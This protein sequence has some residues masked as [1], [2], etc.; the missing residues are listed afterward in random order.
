MSVMDAKPGSPLPLALQEKLLERGRRIHVR[1]N[2]IVVTA[3]ATDTD[4]F[5]VIEGMLQVSLMSARGREL[6]FR[7]I[8]P[9][10]LFGEMAAIEAQP[11]SATVTA[12]RDSTLALIKG[13]AFVDFLENVPGAGLWLACELSQHLRQTTDDLFQLATL[14]V[15][16]RVQCEI[17]R[18]AHVA[19]ITDD[20]AEIASAPT[21][22]AIATRIGSHREAVTRELGSLARLGVIAQR[23]RSLTVLSVTR[24]AEEVRRSTGDNAA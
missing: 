16:A 2:Q 24:L 18:L 14:P 8:G 11:R 9:G 6:T 10:A 21:H 20:Q 23:G 4:V 7:D 12:M 17:L 22:S 13:E 5:L 15:T 1:R 19:G 3:G